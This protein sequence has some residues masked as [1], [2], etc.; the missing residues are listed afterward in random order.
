MNYSKILAG[1]A[2][3]FVLGCQDPPTSDSLPASSSTLQLA[4]ILP[5]DQI[6]PLHDRLADPGKGKPL[7]EIDGDIAL[8]MRE[9]PGD[10]SWTLVEANIL[11]SAELKPA[12]DKGST[13][14]IYGTSRDQVLFEVA[15]YL[16]KSYAVHGRRDGM[17]LH[18]SLN[19]TGE[20]AT[21]DRMWLELP[22]GQA[23]SL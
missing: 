23:K 12:K 5:V 4:R 16:E 9:I 21:F 8:S 3:L 18:I 1:V 14:N 13:W 15:G 6:F 7:I 22:N 20:G 2:S 17:T 11:A 19:I 10:C